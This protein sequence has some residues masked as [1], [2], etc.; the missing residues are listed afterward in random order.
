MAVNQ[1]RTA[2]VTGASGGLG[3]QFAKI[4]AREGFHLVLVARSEGKLKQLA[5]ELRDQ[6]NISVRV[7]P[8]DL[9]APAAPDQLC[10]E[11]DAEGIQI[12]VLINNAGFASYGYFWETP[13]AAELE[14]MQVNMGA[15]THLTKLLLPGMK[16]RGYGRVLNVASTAAFQPGPLMA[17]YYATKAYVLSFSEAI[18]CELEGSGVYVTAL[19]PGPTES[20]FQKRAAMEDS[21]LVQNGLMTA[22]EVAEV[23]YRALMQGKTSVI[24]GFRNRLIALAP[25]FFPRT[26]VT[27]VV[28]NMQQRVGH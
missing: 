18:A 25:R 23:G 1:K 24:P 9:G 28:M 5:D 2:L 15:L 20:D 17:V 22:S 12:D 26:T 27:H 16:A 21:K 11:L 8:K 3:Y 19:C 7:L 13:L 10:K 14:M 4:L 6:H